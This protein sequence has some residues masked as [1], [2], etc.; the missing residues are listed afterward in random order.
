MKRDLREN[1]LKYNDYELL[2]MNGLSSEEARDIL[3]EKYMFMIKKM[4]VKFNVQPNEKDDYFQEGLIALNKAIKTYKET[5]NMTFTRF[6]EMLIYHRFVDL[7]RIKKKRNE[8]NVSLDVIDYIIPEPK[9]TPMLY[10]GNVFELLKLSKRER[11][12]YE[13]I[14]NQGKTNKEVS[15]ILGMKITQVY[16][17]TDRI[18]KKNVHISW[19][20]DL[21][22]VNI[23][24]ILQN[25]S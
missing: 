24:A 17:T 22:T 6:V 10:E 12:V 20:K 11:Q 3:F 14:Y 25:Y 8:E 16:S 19:L 18:R 9:P 21:N 23:F 4:I 7:T 5:S 15:E 13:L 2:Y 1:L